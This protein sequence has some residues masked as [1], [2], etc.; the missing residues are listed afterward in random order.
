M[1][2]TKTP[3]EKLK[4]FKQMNK[5]A[6]ET[7]AKREGFTDAAS[8]LVYLEKEASKGASS[9]YKS[10]GSTSSSSKSKKSTT[11]TV[12]VADVLD[13]SGSMNGEKFNAALSGINI[14]I[15]N[16]K[17]DT[18]PIEYTYTLCDFSDSVLFPQLLK[19]IIDV[20]KV[21]G[22][23]RG[24]TA[25]FDAIGKTV[26]KISEAVGPNDKVLINIYTDG[27]EN[28]SRTFRA[29]QISNIIEDLSSKGWTF[30][31]IGTDADV[32]YAQSMLK[33][34]SSNTL[35]YDG[36]ATGLEA[37]MIKTNSARVNYSNKVSKGEDVS[38]GFFKDIK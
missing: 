7:K 31:F 1:S 37:S 3:Q 10:N 12:H 38:K 21:S 27:Q 17:S 28:A 36:T 19:P 33:F 5:V 34:D 13:A 20:R 8:Y 29:G 32:A 4:S 22:A 9:S 16:L 6:R 25:L 18:N 2:T 14:G 24:S 26:E 35:V 15:A 23:T 30:T 11:V